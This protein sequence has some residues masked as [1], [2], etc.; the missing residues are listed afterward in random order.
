MKKLFSND[1]FIIFYSF[2]IGLVGLYTKSFFK[3]LLDKYNIFNVMLI[4]AI[5]GLTVLLPIMLYLVF[6]SK[7]KYLKIL[8]N[9]TQKEILYLFV[10]NI[11]GIITGY[12]G[13]SFLKNNKV[14]K[15]II[16]DIIIGIFLSFIGMYFFENKTI[17]KKN[18]F[19]LIFICIGAYLML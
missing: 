15:L 16:L 11:L 6:N 4:E 17:S 3:K 9:I 14:S 12:V 8:K 1:V 19:G 5:I 13:S 10:L 7:F 18:I 2:L